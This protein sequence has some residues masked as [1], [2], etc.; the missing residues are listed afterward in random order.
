MDLK[1]LH[2]AKCCILTILPISPLRAWK[3][4][5]IWC[6][7]FFSYVYIYFLRETTQSAISQ[8]DLSGNY[9]FGC[10]GVIDKEY[11]RDL[12]MDDTIVWFVD[13][14]RVKKYCQFVMFLLFNL[15]F[16]ISTPNTLYF[17]NFFIYFIVWWTRENIINVNVMNWYFL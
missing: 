11:H 6:I 3:M 1:V 8:R 17:S 7:F 12:G 5:K 4:Y 16:K 15:I 9:E 10:I 13:I 2:F 14:W